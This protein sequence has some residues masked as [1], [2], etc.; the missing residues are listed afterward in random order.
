MTQSSPEALD[1]ERQLREQWMLISFT[2]AKTD[3]TDMYG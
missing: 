2:P 3:F 1:T